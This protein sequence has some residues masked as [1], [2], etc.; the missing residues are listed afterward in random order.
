[1]I[2]SNYYYGDRCASKNLIK[3]S[4]W[5]NIRPAQSIWICITLKALKFTRLYVLLYVHISAYGFTACSLRYHTVY[6][7]ALRPRVFVL[8]VTIDLRNHGFW[9]KT[10]FHDK[11][12]ESKKWIILLIVVS[13]VI[14]WKLLQRITGVLIKVHLI[15]RYWTIILYCTTSSRKQ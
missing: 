3:Y 9:Y 11:V 15:Q 13:P 5:S 4:M 6:E 14:H 1:M 2:K 7:I 12:N 8:H 10:S